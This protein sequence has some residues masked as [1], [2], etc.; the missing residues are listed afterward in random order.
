MGRC[1][2]EMEGEKSTSLKSAVPTKACHIESKSASS[3]TFNT[4]RTICAIIALPSHHKKTLEIRNNVSHHLARHKNQTRNTNLLLPACCPSPTL[5][6]LVFDLNN[7]IQNLRHSI[8]LTPKS[9]DFTSTINPE[10]RFS[11]HST[12]TKNS[13]IRNEH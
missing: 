13:S 4:R 9:S 10:S 12:K 6:R 1:V 7:R 2:S 8:A 5:Q 3:V 11:I